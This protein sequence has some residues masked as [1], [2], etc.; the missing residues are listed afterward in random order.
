MTRVRQLTTRSG[1]VLCMDRL[2]EPA[3]E[4]LGIDRLRY[5]GGQEA[6]CLGTRGLQ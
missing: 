1:T 6:D 2:P 3:V 4:I 5:P